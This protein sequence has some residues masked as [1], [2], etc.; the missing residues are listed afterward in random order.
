MEILTESDLWDQ[1]ADF[2]S[3]YDPNP[4]PVGYMNSTKFI[5]LLIKSKFKLT[6]KAKEEI[7]KNRYDQM[8]LIE[9]SA[10]LATRNLAT[11]EMLDEIWSPFFE[12]VLDYQAR[13]SA[14]DFTDDFIL[15]EINFQV[16]DVIQRLTIR[17]AVDLIK[18]L[19]NSH[20]GKWI[21]KKYSKKTKEYINS[22]RPIQDYVNQM[23]NSKDSF[24]NK[25]PYRTS[26]LLNI[27]YPGWE[28]ND[29]FFVK[30]KDLFKKRKFY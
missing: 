27:A 25:E 13:M 15:R 5:K 20:Y 9:V 7:Y 14:V 4:S 24:G 12:I 18:P 2:Y 21:F 10:N 17:R 11:P 26:L 29:S 22:H 1:A 19:Y 8:F 30:T 28:K 16:H 3:D 23:R 6:K